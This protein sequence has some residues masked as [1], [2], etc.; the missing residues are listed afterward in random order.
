[1]NVL[2][3]GCGNIGAQYDLYSDEVHTHAKAWKL[4]FDIN[5]SVFDLDEELTTQVSQIYDCKVL[6][7]I[8]ENSF[9]SFDA[10][11]I[12]TPTHTH[13]D[14]LEHAFK[15][16]VKTVICEKPI[17]LKISELETILEMQNPKTKVIVNYFRR[18]LPEF[19]KLKNYINTLL[20]GME[21]V[22]N[23]NVTYQRGF[24]N[25]CSHAFDLLEFLLEKK[26][27]LSD[28][29]VKNRVYDHFPNDPT[30][31]FQSKWDNID[32]SVVGLIGV[33]FSH[34]EI[35]IFFKQHRISIHNAG[36]DI[37]FYQSQ[38]NGRFLKPLKC[39]SD[40]SVSG[41]MSNYMKYVIEEAV[42]LNSDTSRKDNFKTSIEL[43]RTMLNFLNI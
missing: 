28:V 36:N 19:I 38:M 18:F 15:A 23:I 27:I 7:K 1:M 30:L 11:S 39:L 37:V 40:I 9:D 8:D 16:G 43:N 34:F 25:N 22:T 29:S 32:L 14:F 21:D 6:N 33:E 10:I 12:C 5:L 24:I 3:I 20:A 4:L 17:S 13:I 42:L 41:C 31:S 35:E 26:L 2:L